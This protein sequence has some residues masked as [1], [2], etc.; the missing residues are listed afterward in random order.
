MTAKDPEEEARL[1][2]LE[3]ELEH[4]HEDV[5]DLKHDF[6]EFRNEVRDR[7]NGS[8]NRMVMFAISVATS[9]FAIALTIILRT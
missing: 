6:H 7:F 5:R 2:H 1:V 3:D 8:D 9:A 4:T